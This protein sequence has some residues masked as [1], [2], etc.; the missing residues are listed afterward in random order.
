MVDQRCVQW[1]CSNV[2]ENILQAE[3]NF[4]VCEAFYED[5]EAE[6]NPMT[7]QVSGTCRFLG[8]QRG[9]LSVTAKWVRVHTYMASTF[10]I[11]SLY[12]SNMLGTAVVCKCGT[13]P[14]FRLDKHV[15]AA[16]NTAKLNLEFQTTG[17][18][19][20]KVKSLEV[21]VNFMFLL[22]LC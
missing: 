9:K 18:F 10:S 5:S 12:A 3:Q 22:Y 7:K 11:S 13:H 19:T 8:L 20:L 4:V 16:G 21:K 14:P 15:Y 17:A 2:F 1:V 6:D